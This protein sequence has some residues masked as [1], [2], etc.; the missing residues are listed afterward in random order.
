MSKSRSV[1]RMAAASGVVFA[2]T[3]AGQGLSSAQPNQSPETKASLLI[4]PAV[5]YLETHFEARVL[6]KNGSEIKSGKFATRCTGF[7]VSSDGYIGTAGHCV[8]L[9][10]QRADI[11]RAVAKTMAGNSGKTADQWFDYGTTNWTVQVAQKGSQPDLQVLVS[12]AGQRD[13]DVKPVQARLV[14]VRPLGEGDVALLKVELNGKTLPAATLSKQEPAIGQQ[15]LAVG[16]PASTDQVTDFSLDPAVKSGTIS[17]KQTLKTQPLLQISAP[18]SQGMSGGPTV[19][20]QGD[21]LGVISFNPQDEQQPFNFVSP[22]QGLK[23]LLQSQGVDI[24]PNPAD[25]AFR[26][27]VNAYVAGRYSDAISNFDNALQLSPGYPGAFDLRTDAVKLRAQ[28]GDV[29][30]GSGVKSWMVVLAA[31]VVLALVGGGALVFVLSRRNKEPA[32]A[33]GS[34]PPT[35]PGG[36]SAP[37]PPTVGAPSGAPAT[38][39]PSPGVAAAPPPQSGG[40]EVNC[41]NCGY[42]LAPGAQFCPR[43]GKPQR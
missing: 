31:V 23:E 4:K 9:D 39:A 12:G 30:S 27:G 25:T 26:N 13:K 43:C 41:S 11:I 18:T 29:G 2:M 35:N 1:I 40:A 10:S 16:Y 20:M 17:A 15:I 14:S 7:S 32:L 37:R 19:D 36:T 3:C 24:K 6:D 42:S 34:W 5:V 21:V 38:A 33:S 22:V 28:S 8:D